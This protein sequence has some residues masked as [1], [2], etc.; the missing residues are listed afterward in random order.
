L[1]D[2]R[3]SGARSHVLLRLASSPPLLSPKVSGI[4]IDGPCRGATVL[5]MFS[6]SVSPLVCFCA[7]LFHVCVI[8]VVSVLSML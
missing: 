5:L 3:Q 1:A 4:L 7:G 2:T 8:V 6:D